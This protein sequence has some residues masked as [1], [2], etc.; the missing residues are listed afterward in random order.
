MRKKQ[1]L[2]ANFCYIRTF[3]CETGSHLI[4]TT[5]VHLCLSLHSGSQNDILW[6]EDLFRQMMLLVRW[7]LS[8]T[9]L[10]NLY[11]YFLCLLPFS[12]IICGLQFSHKFWSEWHVDYVWLIR[13]QSN[14]VSDQSNVSFLRYPNILMRT[15]FR[16]ALSLNDSWGIWRFSVLVCWQMPWS[17]IY[18]CCQL[19]KLNFIISMTRAVVLMIVPELIIIFRYKPLIMQIYDWSMI[20]Q[21]IPS[22]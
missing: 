19:Y 2:T 21:S 7:A 3:S 8:L 20:V 9:Y 10:L 15:L 11:R 5:K 13:Y 1:K 16:D 17:V 4:L 6:T 22:L 12:S 18:L 14:S